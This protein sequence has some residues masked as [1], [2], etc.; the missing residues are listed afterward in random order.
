MSTDS[1]A[2]TTTTVS[3]ADR[4]YQSYL[5]AMNSK[6]PY[7]SPQESSDDIYVEPLEN[8][9]Q[10]YQSY[11]DNMN[12]KAPYTAPA[13]E[14]PTE[15]PDVP[16]TT[17]NEDAYQKALQSV[18]ASYQA[19]EDARARA[20]QENYNN[21]VRQAQNS[22]NAGKDSLRQNTDDALR[23]A[24]ISYMLGQRGLNQ[25]LANG[26]VN[27]GALE[28]VLANLYNNYGNNRASIEN[29]YNNSLADLVANY[30]NNVANLGANYNTNYANALA[31]YNNQIAST[32]SNYA[33]TL[34]NMLAKQNGT[35][36]T[37]TA[38]T[39]SVADVHKVSRADVLSGIGAYKN[40]IAGLVEYLQSPLL[41]DYSSDELFYLASQ[42][43]VPRSA[44][45]NYLSGNNDSG[46]LNADPIKRAMEE[47]LIKNMGITGV[48]K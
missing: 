24:Y 17:G 20:L 33:S 11:I 4:I 31:D 10:I 25:Q 38:N 39:G 5:E 6:A 46:N 35:A 48:I 14:T 2:R 43:G 1:G 26:G 34:A 22:F 7:T 9:D 45:D 21:A 28:S 19:A 36:D 8:Y 41:D 16:G 13:T 29:A 47:E 15:T 18:Y 37:S 40:N 30:N 32:Q 12:S 44:I 42:I 3:D 23:Q 27:G